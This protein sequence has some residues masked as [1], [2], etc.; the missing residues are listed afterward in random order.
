MFTLDLYQGTGLIIFR[1][2]E[3]ETLSIGELAKQAH[4]N[5]DS[6]CLKPS[7]EKMY[8]QRPDWQLPDF[9]RAL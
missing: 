8:R 2:F 6:G 5:I 3:M 7:V 1:R 4:V 9:G